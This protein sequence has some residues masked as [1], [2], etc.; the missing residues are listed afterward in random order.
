MLMQKQKEARSKTNMIFGVLSVTVVVMSFLAAPFGMGMALADREHRGRDRENSRN[1][2]GAGAVRSQTGHT[3]RG[4]DENED[5]EKEIMNQFSSTSVSASSAISN[6]TSAVSA[7]ALD[8][9]DQNEDQDDQDENHGFGGNGNKNNNPPVNFAEIESKIQELIA[10]V[11]KLEAEIARLFGTVNTVPPVISGVFVSHSSTS[12]ADIVWTTNELATSKVYFGTSTPVNLAAA[13]IA[14]DP[15]FVLN[16]SIHLSGLNASTTYFFVAESA[17]MSN[18]IARSAEMSFT[19]APIS[20]VLP[21]I[22]AVTVANIASSTAEVRWTTNEPATSK[23][24][25]GTSTPVN[26]VTA[27]SVSDSAFVLN[28]S[29]PLSGL[30]ASTTYFFVAESKDAAN[31]VATS[32]QQNFATIH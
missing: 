22:S 2:S 16:H 25:F 13:Q 28:H 31:N 4:G 10:S 11:L 5:D 8:Q 20:A 6:S 3:A 19:T 29:I 27:T 17:D 32:A 7:S 9:E 15:S 12:T 26:L 1:N 23:V 18:N 24:H 14:A 21:V 30:A